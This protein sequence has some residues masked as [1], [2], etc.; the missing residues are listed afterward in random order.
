M[1]FL[2]TLLLALAMLVP[3]Y[4]LSGGTFYL[5]EGLLQELSFGQG[6]PL[7]NYITH[8]FTHVGLVHFAGNFVPLVLFGVLLETGVGFVHV[9]AIFLFSGLLSSV[10]FAFLNPAV[11]LVGASTGVS[12]IMAAATAISPKKALALLIAT[13]L[14]LL[15]VNPLM[16]LYN[17]A[18]VD[19]L[20]EQKAGLEEKVQVLLSENKIQEALEQ[21][22]SLVKVSAVLEQTKGGIQREK[23]IPTDVLVH[24]FGALFG[25]VYV[26][27]FRRDK[28][29]EGAVEFEEIGDF[30]YSKLKRE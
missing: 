8:L 16:G 15:M 2:A 27:V 30:L 18:Q 25:A 17:S 1:K 19:R 14:L 26:F 7:G 10:L 3:F 22:D 28:L 13:P 12:G 20:A 23:E 4:L 21:N 29:R 11:V 24:L 9:L 5:Q 6:A